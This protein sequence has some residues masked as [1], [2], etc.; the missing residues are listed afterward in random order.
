V[1]LPYAEGK[2]I[3]EAERVNNGNYNFHLLNALGC[4]QQAGCL[5]RGQEAIL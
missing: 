3:K 1:Q 4:T 5:Q 2:E